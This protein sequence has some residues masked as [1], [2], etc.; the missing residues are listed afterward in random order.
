M[1]QEEVGPANGLKVSALEYYIERYD[2]T[3][4]EKDNSALRIVK[5]ATKEYLRKNKLKGFIN[6]DIV[7]VCRIKD[8]L[9][10]C[11]ELGFECK[12]F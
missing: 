3:E 2:L 5:K 10:K 9:L 8:G 4:K 11:N 12:P 1:K 6:D 7:C